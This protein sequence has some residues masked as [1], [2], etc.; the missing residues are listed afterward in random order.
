VGFPVAFA[1]LSFFEEGQGEL[2]LGGV[3]TVV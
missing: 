3:V 2:R 1:C